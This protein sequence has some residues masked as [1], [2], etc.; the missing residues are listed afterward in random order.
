MNRNSINLIRKFP[1]RPIKIS[2]TLIAI[3]CVAMVAWYLRWRCVRTL[4]IDHDER[5]YLSIA[6]TYA[7]AFRQGRLV[8]IIG[9]SDDI[10]NP[11]FARM[12]YG[13]AIDIVQPDF[14][15]INK[16]DFI[17]GEPLY[18]KNPAK[19]MLLTARSVSAWFGVLG[20]VLLAVINPLA[21]LFLAVHTFAVK[22]TSVVYLEAIPSLTSL[23]CILAFNRWFRL[24]H[25]NT[26]Q[27]LFNKIQA[28]DLWLGVSAVTLGLSAASKYMYATAGIASLVYMLGQTLIDRR[29]IKSAVRPLLIWGGIA[30]LTFFAADPV[31][32]PDPLGNLIKSIL[33]NYNFSRSNYARVSGYPMWQPLFWLSKPVTAH[34]TWA[35]PTEPFIFLVRLDVP[36]NLLALV[37]LPRL[38]KR[39][40]LYAVWLITGL[41]FLLVWANK[42]PQYVLILLA[43]LCLSAAQGVVTLIDPLFG[44]GKRAI[45]HYLPTL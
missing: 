11:V 10:D 4:P 31:L 36:I 35:I 30:L 37:G 6:R 24:H 19:P 3:L 39:Y 5:I 8:D 38:F 23:L 18:K 16:K 1:W 13:A 28:A 40:P 9:Y 21:G 2:L 27:L 20:A 25:S 22:Y 14:P 29:S 32:W 43:P 33:H 15:E 42:W 41:V 44:F 34:N 45:K 7:Y 17:I 12:V 26:S